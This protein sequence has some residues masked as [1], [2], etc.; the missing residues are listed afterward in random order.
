[1]VSNAV[2]DGAN[3]I[4]LSCEAS[5][6]NNVVEAIKILSSCCIEAEKLMEFRIDHFREA[7]V[8]NLT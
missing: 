6:A 4:M 5:Q 7:S 3:F 8:A 2:L 1:M